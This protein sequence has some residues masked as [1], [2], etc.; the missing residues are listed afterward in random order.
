MGVFIGPAAPLGYG[1]AMR[2]PLA[3]LVLVALLAACG[4]RTTTPVPVP[5]AP[6]ATTPVSAEDARLLALVNEARA[7]TTSCGAEGTFPPAGPLTIDPRLSRAAL[8][9]STEMRRR[10]V[11]SHI[12]AD[13]SHVGD[14]VT[15]Q[16]YA[17]RSV[18][19]NVARGYETPESVV[20]GWLASAGHCANIMAADFVHL[21]VGRDDLYWTQ[22]FGRPR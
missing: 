11:M 12:G 22:V 10:D 21:G 17:W 16:G 8:G 6:A 13:G 20:S 7:T 9:H 19:E 15:R 2:L 1:G 14:R 5:W 4:G 18:G 3:T